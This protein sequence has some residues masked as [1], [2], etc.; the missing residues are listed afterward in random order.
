[1]TAAGRQRLP[2][3]AGIVVALLAAV[4]II[5][6]HRPQRL[7]VQRGVAVR[8]AMR[9]PTVA[10][11]RAG[12]HWNEV[13]VTAIDDH[14]VYVGFLA[15]GQLVAE[16]AVDRTGHVLSGVNDRAM[17]VPYGDW[18]AY[19]PAVLV[20]LGA[21]FA[22]MAGVAPLRRWRNLDVLA[23]IS[24]VVPVV[25]FKQRYLSASVE[26]AAP[27][28]AYLL[29]RCAGKGFGPAREPAA[30]T[31]LTAVVMSGVDVARR[32][33]WLRALFVVL[34]L[35]YVMVGISSP[36]A[37]DVIYAVMEGATKLIH[38]V[39]P[40]GHMPPGIVHGDTYPILSYALYTPLALLTPVNS[41]WESVDLGLA[42]AVVAALVA[43][44]AVF[45][46]IAGPRRSSGETR[47]VEVEEAGLRAAL[48]WLAFPSVLITVSTGTTDA[49]LAAMLAVAVLLW[50][51]PALCAG[52][53]AA[54]GWFKFAPFALLP[55]PLAPLRGRRLV[56]ALAA[57]VV[58]SAPLVA[59]LFALGGLHGPQAMLHAISF[60]FTRG[61]EQSVWSALGIDGLQPLVQG[62]VLGLI[63]AAVVKLRVDPALAGDRARMAALTAAILIGLQLSADYWAFL[64][65]A[66]IVPMLGG[67]LLADR[68][69]AVATAAAPASLSPA[70]PAPSMAG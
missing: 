28:M 46:A 11:A 56:R 47:P 20:V 4:A 26:A 43:A 41:V 33:R 61:S 35:V 6:T 3:A 55:L 2:L 64:Y 16:A 1:M 12:S 17:R 23:A 39:L 40:Y 50:R 44:W 25:L 53:L 30:S 19:Q 59:L 63:A 7:A 60:Q 67:S 29:F 57:I 52:M 13:T 38:G 36:D 70:A 27:G 49:V 69:G 45:R 66:W 32:V 42:A 9:D 22:L 48:A 62:C 54:A 51:R 68:S 8:A 58:V 65:L 34:A 5:L 10:E 18:I 24:L 37:V 14:L 31:P 15:N 21:L